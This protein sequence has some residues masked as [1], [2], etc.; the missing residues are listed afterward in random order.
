MSE[1]DKIFTRIREAL[2]ST[3]RPAHGRGLPTT[4]EHREVLP[5][6]DTTVEVSN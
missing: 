3:A 5:P 1:R 6:V 4:A 2:E